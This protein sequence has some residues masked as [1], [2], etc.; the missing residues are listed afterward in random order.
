MP[1]PLELIRTAGGPPNGGLEL[2]FV[3]GTG[4]VVSPPVGVFLNGSLRRV[5]WKTATVLG[6]RMRVQLEETASVHSF[7]VL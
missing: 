7:L 3:M 2:R 1:R 4:K 5:N 6:F